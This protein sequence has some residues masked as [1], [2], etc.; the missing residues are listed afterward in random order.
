MF[1]VRQSGAYTVLMFLALLGL[2]GYCIYGAWSP[3]IHFYWEILPYRTFNRLLFTVLILS[4][5][6]IPINMYTAKNE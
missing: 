3:N 2:V 6:Q 1:L 5:L 4:L